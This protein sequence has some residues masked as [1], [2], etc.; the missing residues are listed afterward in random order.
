MGRD[1]SWPTVRDIQEPGTSTFLSSDEELLSA[2][3]ENRMHIEKE[4]KGNKTILTVIL[5]L[6]NAATL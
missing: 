5:N 3:E 6:P 2:S 1:L 4:D